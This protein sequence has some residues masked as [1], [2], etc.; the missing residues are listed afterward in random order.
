MAMKENILSEVLI[1]SGECIEIMMRGASPEPSG[2]AAAAAAS[3]G[4]RNRH[5]KHVR[6]VDQFDLYQYPNI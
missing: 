3:T 1:P 6:T 2:R 5:R 4:G